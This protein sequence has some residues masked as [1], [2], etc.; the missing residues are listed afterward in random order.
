MESHITQKVD[1]LDMD[2]IFTYRPGII[3]CHF[4]DF[5]GDSKEL[6]PSPAKKKSYNVPGRAERTPGNSA[7]RP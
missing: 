1:T 3:S 7:G 6:P 5:E 4:C 2:E